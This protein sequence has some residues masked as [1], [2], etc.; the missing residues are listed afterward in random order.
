[1][2]KCIR[3]LALVCLLSLI[4][5]PAAHS[6]ESE[7][8]SLPETHRVIK[9]ESFI[10]F[11]AYVNE[12]VSEGRFTDYDVQIAFD[13]RRPEISQI[14]ATI[15]LSP[16]SITSDYDEVA[17][18]LVGHEWLDVA[19]HPAAQFK[20]RSIEGNSSN[21][22][23]GKGELTL[24]GVTKPVDFYLMLNQWG[25]KPGESRLT[26]DMIIV[27]KRLD[28]GIGKGDWQDTDSV[29]NEVTITA[30]MVTE[31]VAN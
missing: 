7:G 2:V 20:T 3:A 8:T 15:R 24:L 1:M 16:N 5:A 29:A 30:H 28:Y 4:T 12:A 23:Q 19:S 27:L 14:S 31:P 13:P 18:A 25:N 9:E 21:I 22:F 10:Q 11:S 17:K 26:G 6:A